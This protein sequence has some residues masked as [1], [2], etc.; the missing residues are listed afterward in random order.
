MKKFL[1]LAFECA[2]V[3]IMWLGVAAMGALTASLF[4]DILK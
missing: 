2:L 1:D 3:L 4:M